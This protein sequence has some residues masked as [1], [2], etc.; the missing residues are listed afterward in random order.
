[1]DYIIVDE[2]PYFLEVNTIP[3]MTRESIVP[4]Q[5]NMFGLDLT[6][7]ISLLLDEALAH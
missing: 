7:L 2:S 5:A 1:M 4:K 3:G 6:S